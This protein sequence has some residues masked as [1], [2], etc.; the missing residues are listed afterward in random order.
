MP[1]FGQSQVGHLPGL[2]SASSSV[3]APGGV[4]LAG[5]PHVRRHGSARP[6]AGPP[7]PNEYPPL[8]VSDSCGGQ[9]ALPRGE[10]L[11]DAHVEVMSWSGGSFRTVERLLSRAPAS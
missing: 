6:A 5:S 11:V 7:L 3:V 4:G 2:P 1:A 8:L 10:V 9:G